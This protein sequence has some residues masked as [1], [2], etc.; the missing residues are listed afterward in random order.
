ME[1]GEKGILCESGTVPAAVIRLEGDK[2]E[3]RPTPFFRLL[4]F[5]GVRTVGPLPNVRLGEV[6]SSDLSFENVVRRKGRT[7]SLCL[8]ESF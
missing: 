8:F 1:H 6:S 2:S 7:Q 5:S 4:L 3:Y